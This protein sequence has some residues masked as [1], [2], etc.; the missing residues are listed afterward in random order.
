MYP[1]IKEYMVE[2]EQAIKYLDRCMTYEPQF[3]P[4]VKYIIK[5]IR[6]NWFQTFGDLVFRYFYPVGCNYTHLEDCECYLFENNQLAIRKFSGEFYP[7][8]VLNYTTSMITTELPNED[9]ARPRVEGEL[10]PEF[11]IAKYLI[12]KG[13]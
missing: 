9:P 12:D 8:C 10:H 3:W 5:Q 7:V 11:I 6:H 1:D 2:Y 4:T 13:F